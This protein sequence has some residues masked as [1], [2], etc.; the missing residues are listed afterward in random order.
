MNL[1][2]YQARELFSK[3]GL[4]YPAG[5]VANTPREAGN[6]AAEIGKPVVVK[7]QVLTGGRGKA[8]GVRLAENAAQAETQASQ[9]FGLNIKGYPVE[10][11]LVTE[12]ADIAREFY[13]GVIIDRVS[14]MPVLMASAAGGVDIEEVSQQTP[15]KI[16]SLPIDPLLGL[17]EFQARQIGFSLDL[18]SAQVRQFSSIALSLYRGFANMDASLCEINPLITDRSGN[19]QAL[20]AKL[21]IDDN[22][23]FRQ[24]ELAALR[25]LDS[26]DPLE[27]QAREQGLSYVKLDGEVGCIVNG[28]GLAMA[29][30]DLVKLYGAEPANFLDIGGGARAERV[31]EALR[32]VISGP[33]VKAVLINIFGGITR[34]DEVATGIVAALD[35]VK[36]GVPIVVR[37]VGTNEEEG[38]RI[39][40]Q[41]GLT[42]VT[43]VTEAAK[44]VI[45]KLGS[46]GESK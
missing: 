13:L 11:V 16:F 15:E 3:F 44:A 9:I 29:T 46:D 4:P 14:R 32:L 18:T 5:R 12:A 36:V 1:H 8:G 33:N 45:D 28:A 37:L 27:R 40:E 10:R 31:A 30:M 22:A 25:D 41:A 34:G 7:A 17:Q 38:R 42:A 19:L 35:Q 24:A 21:S 43:S 6:I 39:L 23:L 2:E 20:D 26:E